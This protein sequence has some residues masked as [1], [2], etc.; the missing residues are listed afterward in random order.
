MKKGLLPELWKGELVNSKEQIKELFF[1]MNWRDA[2]ELQVKLLRV[3]QEKCIER[4]GSSHQSGCPHYCGYYP[5]LE[6]ELAE[7]RFSLDL[8]YRLNV[9]QIVSSPLRERT[10]DISA[11]ANHFINYYNCKAGKKNL[12]VYLTKF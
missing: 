7:R 2:R 9:F 8:Y 3:L 12:Q 5:Q 4:I 6:K 1:L 10:E 11:L